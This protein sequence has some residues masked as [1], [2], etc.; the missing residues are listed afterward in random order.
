MGGTKAAKESQ[1]AIRER[2]RESDR[3]NER[4]REGESGRGG[5]CVI[6]RNMNAQLT[7]CV[8]SKSQTKQQE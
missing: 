4:G 1:Q 2:E 6:S 8:N 3:V 7:K 5:E